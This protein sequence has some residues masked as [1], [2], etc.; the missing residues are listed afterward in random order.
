MTNMPEPLS[1]DLTVKLP[2]VTA[3]LAHP[4]LDPALDQKVSVTLTLSAS[5]AEDIGGVI[6][7]I[8]DLLKIAVPPS[9]EITRTTSPEMF[10]L[11]L[12]RMC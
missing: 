7:A 6:S 9:Y 3:G 2:T 5:A 1:K 11:N 10:K 8:A 12:K 4:F